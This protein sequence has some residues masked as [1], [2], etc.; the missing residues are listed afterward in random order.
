M[1]NPMASDHLEKIA[2][3]MLDNK[4]KE[5]EFSKDTNIYIVLS[6]PRSDMGKGNIAAHLLTH[7]PNSDAVKFDG[8]LNTNANGRHT[9]KGHDDFGIY[10]K[11]NPSKKFSDERYLLGGYL[12]K[13]FIDEYGE[14]ENLSFRPHFT[15]YFIGKLGYI[16]H[17]IG[18]PKNFILEVGGTISDWEVDP[19]I[20]PVINYLKGNH[21]KSCKIILLSELAYS[22]EH[23]KTRSIQLSVSEFLKRTIVPDVLL[24]REPI[25]M[26]INTDKDRAIIEK[27]VR[28]KLEDSI[29]L[30][31]LPQIILGIPFYKKEKLGDLSNYIKEKLIPA[32][33]K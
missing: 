6:H 30:H 32:L 11:F 7:L 22:E 19:Y 5:N 31:L 17:Q 12:Y 23:P 13:E 33:Y 26:I 29:G 4:I 28:D 27:T 18:Q 1:I 16:W 21:G 8:L 25:E 20:T 15:K 2:L 14:Y 9:A 3:K 24:Y 10:E